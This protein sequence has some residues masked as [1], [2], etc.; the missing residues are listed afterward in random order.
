MIFGTCPF[1]K[2][3]EFL[4]FIVQLTLTVN[5]L[6]LLLGDRLRL[7]FSGLCND[8][9]LLIFSI[10]NLLGLSLT[11]GDGRCRHTIVQHSFLT[12]IEVNFEFFFFF[13]C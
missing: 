6:C 5:F 1:W 4:Y 12:L 13:L 7:N 3:S 2:S 11:F 8:V 9:S 10:G